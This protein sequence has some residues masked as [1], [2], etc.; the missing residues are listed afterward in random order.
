L[1]GLELPIADM[2]DPKNEELYFDANTPCFTKLTSKE[3][4]YSQLV[5]FLLNRI[6]SILK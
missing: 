2:E 6:L 5:T 1:K 4:L 3:H